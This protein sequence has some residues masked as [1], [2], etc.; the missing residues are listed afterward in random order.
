MWQREQTIKLIK[1]ASNTTFCH[2]IATLKRTKNKSPR[3]PLAAFAASPSRACLCSSSWCCWHH[4][5]CA[6]LGTT[7]L[8]LLQGC[9]CNKIRETG[10]TD[11]H[12]QFWDELRLLMPSFPMKEVSMYFQLFVPPHHSGPAPEKSSKHELQRNI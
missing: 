8:R 2:F 5:L 4:A 6:V 7:R 3:R 11:S 1:G 9:V 12:S 10:G